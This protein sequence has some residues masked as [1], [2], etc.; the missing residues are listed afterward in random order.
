MEIT[1]T[2]VKIKHAIE[3]VFAQL[4][5]ANTYEMLM[6]DGA[7]FS[8]VDNDSFRFKL[9]SMPEIGLTIIERN[10]GESVVL[11]STSDKV[12]FSLKGTLI[13]REENETEIQLRFQGDFNPM[14]AMMVKKPLTK[15]MESLIG[16]MHKL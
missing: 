2:S 9:G 1:S 10:E 13:A 7:Q 14:M 4:A 3:V 16:N 8:L 11:K 12:E 6:P 15:F 5:D